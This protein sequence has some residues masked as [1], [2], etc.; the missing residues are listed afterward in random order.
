[1]SKSKLPAIPEC[2]ILIGLPAA[3]KTTYF[4]ERY[5]GTH[6][7]I[8]KDLWP[9]T[10]DRNARQRDAIA[11]A[12]LAGRSVVVDNTNPTRSDREAIIQVARA[13]GA[14][15]V[16]CF[17][18][19]TT[20]QAIARNEGRTGRA[21]VPKVAIFTAAKKLQPP[22]LV[23]G[24]RARGQGHPGMMR[25]LE[26]VFLDAGGVLVYP[27]W[28]RVSRELARHGVEVSADAL[29]RAD[30]RAKRTLD[31]GATIKATTDESRGWVY[32]NL[33]LDEAGV[34]R[35]A[36][37]DAALEG[38]RVYHATHNVWET[39][40]DDVAPALER[41]RK[42]GLRLVIV[43]NANGTLH[44]M[45]ARLGLAGRVDVLFDSAREGVEKPDPRLFA[46][47]LER[48][49]ARADST[50]HVG[51]LYHVDVVGAR[52]AGLRAVLF[53]VGNLY[54]DADCPR[55]RSLGELCDRIERGG[56]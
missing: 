4:R 1:M 22:E 19:V 45:F 49:G 29:R 32:F 15:A 37:T 25:R 10:R 31:A 39:V 2:V 55:V 26:T 44:D 16:G 41:L 47:A 6:E 23:E 53:D 48:S 46:I 12:L 52:S 9:S 30:P 21:R 5:A 35:T 50:I 38:L 11:A 24:R 27:N 43:S 36:A 8:S 18:D 54:G 40:P 3:G 56:L 7:H 33:V 20:R 51:D 14:R 42:M 13:H 34:P 28:D 17:L